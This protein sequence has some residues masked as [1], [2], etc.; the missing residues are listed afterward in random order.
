[1]II[2]SSL[3]QTL[4]NDR[5]ICA[6]YRHPVN[7]QLFVARSTSG[8]L[9]C[10][11]PSLEEEDERQKM[12]KEKKH[13]SRRHAPSSTAG[14]PAARGCEELRLDCEKKEDDTAGPKRC[15]ELL[16][17]AGSASDKFFLLLS[18]IVRSLSDD[19]PSHHVFRH[20]R[21]YAANRD[22]MIEKEAAAAVL[23][24]RCTEN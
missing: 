24:T 20:S 7:H 18:L 16:T 22:R 1:M 5:A 3:A 9:C 11:L 2:D 12:E 15:E 23:P 6:S 17:C 8:C 10:A 13:L 19:R 4:S 21:Q 14:L